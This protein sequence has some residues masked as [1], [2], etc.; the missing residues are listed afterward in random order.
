[1][2]QAKLLSFISVHM[3]VEAV[4]LPSCTC[5]P[6]NPRGKCP[7]QECVVWPGVGLLHNRPQQGHFAGHGINSSF[8]TFFRSP[9]LLPTSDLTSASITFR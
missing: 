5:L 3:I 8:K 7:W 1:M 6:M 4:L 9:F 2:H